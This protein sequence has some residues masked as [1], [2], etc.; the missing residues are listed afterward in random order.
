[1]TKW[2]KVFELDERREPVWGSAS[3]LTAAVELGADLR[4]A[5]AFRHNEHMKR[6]LRRRVM[7]SDAQVVL[8]DETGRDL[9]PDDFPENSVAGRHRPAAPPARSMTARHSVSS[10]VVDSSTTRIG[11]SPSSS[12]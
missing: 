9:L 8:M 11:I 12:R 2:S 7:K 5:T 10:S 1:M 4:V 6:G 3:A